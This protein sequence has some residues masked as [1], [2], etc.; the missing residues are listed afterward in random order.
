MTVPVVQV[1]IVWML[2]REDT[3]TVSAA[4]PGAGRAPGG[5]ST[6]RSR[7]LDTAIQPTKSGEMFTLRI[8][9]NGVLAPNNKAENKAAT[10]A[11]PELVTTGSSLD[12][13][14]PDHAGESRLGPHG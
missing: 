5:S 9:A 6:G 2:M 8:F 13:D 1:R 11:A 10:M 4:R 7:C 14:N 3:V 12:R